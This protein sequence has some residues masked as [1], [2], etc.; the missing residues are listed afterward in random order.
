M[1]FPLLGVYLLQHLWFKKWLIPKKNWWPRYLRG[2]E[3]NPLNNSRKLE[4]PFTPRKAQLSRW[5]KTSWWFFPPIWKICN[6]QF[7]SF[8]QGSGW[9]SKY[10]SCHHLEHSTRQFLR[11]SDLF[12]GWWVNT[13]PELKGCWWPTQRLGFNRSRIESPGN[14][15]AMKFVDSA[16]VAFFWRD[17]FRNPYLQTW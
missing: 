9:K 8:P 11:K 10:L 15:L 6:R 14:G 4:I 2:G 16:T 3:G 13:W 5:P 7:G 12:V 17:R 1:D